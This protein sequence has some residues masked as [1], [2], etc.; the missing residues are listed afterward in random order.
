MSA[1]GINARNSSAHDSSSV[2]AEVERRALGLDHGGVGVAERHGA[3]PHP[4]LDEL[5][6]VEVPDAAAL[7]ARDQRRGELGVLVV[8]LGV[9]MAPARYE[10]AQ[11]RGEL[12]STCKLHRSSSRACYHARVRT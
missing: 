12:L 4:V 7:A 11:A 8:A 3:K 5:V 6:A 10:L 2:G 9:G 1:P